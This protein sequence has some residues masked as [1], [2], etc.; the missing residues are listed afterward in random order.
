MAGSSAAAAP[1]AAFRAK[2]PGM[3][4]AC[5]GASLASVALV[6]SSAAA[7][8]QRPQEGVGQNVTSAAAAGRARVAAGDILG[9]GGNSDGQL[10]DGTTQSPRIDPVSM[11]EIGVLTRQVSAGGRHSAVLRSDGLVFVCGSNSWGQLGVGSTTPHATPLEMSVVVR[12]HPPHLP[13]GAPHDR[14]G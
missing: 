12:L 8:P 4:R 13:P 10:G 9:V 14:R 5:V 6:A 2:K 7:L 3:G 1:S 11:E